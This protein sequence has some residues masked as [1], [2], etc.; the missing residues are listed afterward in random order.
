MTRSTQH[1]DPRQKY[2]H[3]QELL[4]RV[5]E[6]STDPV[7]LKQNF[8]TLFRCSQG[9]Q[10]MLA[11]LSAQLQAHKNTFPL[12][13]ELITQVYSALIYVG[14][15][16]GTFV[17]ILLNAKVGRAGTHPERRKLLLG[18][19]YQ[20]YVRVVLDQTKTMQIFAQMLVGFVFGLLQLDPKDYFKSVGYYLGKGIKA[21]EEYSKVG[22]I[23]K[24]L[25]YS[26]RS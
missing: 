1:F 7:N 19:Q 22:D 11:D 13:D 15:D 17:K 20:E 23:T 24:K 16:S 25:E 10:D 4:T 2:P 5:T 26:R 18:K 8:G 6:T 14:V 3:L 9:V 12:D 21:F